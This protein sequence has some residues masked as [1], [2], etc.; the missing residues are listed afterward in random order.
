MTKLK[1]FLA[2]DED[3]A[4]KRLN[5]L[6][7]ETGRVEVLGRSNDPEEARR[8]LIE[9]PVDLLFLDIEMPGMTG[10]EL[11]ASLP[12]QP[13]TILTTAY[14]KYALAAFETHSIDYLVKPVERERLA[15]ALD[16]AERLLAGKEP[17]EW[18]AM[19]NQLAQTLTKPATQYPMRVASKVGGK[20]ELIDLERVTHFYSKDKLT[21]AVAAGKTHIV[22]ETIAELEQKLDPAR[23]CRIHR[24]TLVNLAF[25][26]EL[27][28]W[29]GGGI[30]LRLKDQNRTELQVARERT[31]TMKD[32]L[33]LT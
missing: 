4:L 12:N 24:S 10:F 31:A 20:V 2:D 5:R 11:L 30:L 8:R 23:F 6:L 17:P 33:G 28:P 21:W 26:Q 9:L 14:S 18:Q 16:K 29:L 1:V 3:L 22:E 7:E 25:V 32:K 27:H 19:V 15:K 13:L